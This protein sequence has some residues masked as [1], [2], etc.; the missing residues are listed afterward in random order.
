MRAQTA[1]FLVRWMLNTIGLWLAIRIFGTGYSAEEVDAGFWILILAGL[2]FSIVNAI[3][4]PIAIILALPAILLTLGLFTLVVNGAMVWIALK[5]APGISMKFFYAIITGIVISLVN[6]IVSNVF[7]F[8]MP[9]RA[10]QVE[11]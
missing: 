9:K 1:S 6:Y 8:G 2:T 7:D 5:L 4:R 3:L 11:E 10:K